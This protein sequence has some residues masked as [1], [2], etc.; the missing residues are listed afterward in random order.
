MQT[1]YFFEVLLPYA[2]GCGWLRSPYG[3]DSFTKA[4]EEGTAFANNA[5]A[6]KGESLGVKVVAVETDDKPL[7]GWEPDE[8]SPL[9]R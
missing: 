4:W 7:P 2:P 8:T 9:N 1:K 6:Y 5:M 3:R